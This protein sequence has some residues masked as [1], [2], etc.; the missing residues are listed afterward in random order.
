[1]GKLL[2]EN[3][4][5]TDVTT[6]SN[7]FIDTY[8]PKASGE[9]V[10]I[11]LHL[12]RLIGSKAKDLDLSNI[13]DIF[14]FTEGDIL[15]ALKYWENLGLLSVSKDSN[16]VISG[17]RLEPFGRNEHYIKGV[18]SMQMGSEEMQTNSDSASDKIK[19]PNKKKYT[20]EDI[21]NLEENVEIGQLL[22]IAQAYLAKPLNSTEINSLLYMYDVLH[23][24]ADLIE[25]LMETYISDGVKSITPIEKH[26]CDLY[27]HGIKDVTSAKKYKKNNSDLGKKI[28]DTFGI[29][30]RLAAKDE[31]SFIQIWQNEFG[32][33]EDIIIEACNRTISHTHSPSFKYANSILSSWHKAGVKDLGDISKLD[34]DHEKKSREKYAK[35]KAKGVP[36]KKV[37][38]TAFSTDRSYSYDDLEKKLLNN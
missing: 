11:Y 31:S 12:L 20:P 23:F 22:F 30:G 37:R 29:T 19:L 1:M 21:E 32:Y 7:I 35:L 10:K 24:P 26:A 6:V 28:L 25:Y 34:E 36:T 16:D 27:I 9:F 18:H 33:G 13:A 2:L 4:V 3:S 38:D 14:N 5:A 17:I 8:M 15:R